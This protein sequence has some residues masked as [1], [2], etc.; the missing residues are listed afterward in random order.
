MSQD[1]KDLMVGLLTKEPKFRLG[2]REGVKE[3]LQHKWFKKICLIDI[4]NR[5]VI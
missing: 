4:L 2:A 1:I 3:I 5:R